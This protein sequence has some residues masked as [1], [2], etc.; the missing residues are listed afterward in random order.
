M[1]CWL[2]NVILCF[3]SGALE[4]RASSPSA[5]ID[6]SH[7]CGQISWFVPANGGRKVSVIGMSGESDEARGVEFLR[8]I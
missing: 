6:L 1:S 5:T 8:G 3:T 7:L 2:W 4:L